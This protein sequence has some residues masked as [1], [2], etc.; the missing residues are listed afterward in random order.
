MTAAAAR[1]VAG[2]TALF[3]VIDYEF[4][5][6]DLFGFAAAKLARRIISVGF[7]K[8]LVTFSAFNAFKFD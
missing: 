4:S 5:V 3:T 2:A 6:V 7:D 8:L 1:A